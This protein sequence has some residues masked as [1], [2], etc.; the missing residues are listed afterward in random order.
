MKHQTLGKLL[1]CMISL[2][3]VCA[4]CLSAFAENA[5]DSE[6]FTIEKKTLVKYNGLGGEVTVPEGVEVLGAYAFERARVTKVN[7][8]ETLKEIKDHCFFGCEGLSEITLPASLRKLSDA[9]VF[10]GN[11]SL[12][13]IKV[14]EGNRQYKSV[15][16]V[17]FTANG[18]KML[19][20]PD[21]KSGA[22]EIPEG[23]RQLGYTVFGKPDMPSVTIPATLGKLDGGDFSL[24]PALK[25]IKISEKH[26]T[27]HMAGSAMYDRG[28][29]LIAYV[30]GDEKEELKPEDFEEKTA[31]IGSWAFQGNQYLKKV[32]FPE[33]VRKV[34][35]M[36]FSFAESLEEVIIPASVKSI[37]QYAFV[38]C[39]NL[40]KVTILNPW[41]TMPRDQRG[42]DPL[43]EN[44]FRRSNEDAVL[45]GPAGSNVQK[46]AEA[47]GLKFEA[48]EPAK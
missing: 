27:Y 9:Q 16:G 32:E 3:L 30:C 15:D 1:I 19:Y 38:Y 2:L 40:K 48:L 12:K 33:G 11:R 10:G 44:I 42:Q 43:K 46:Y 45:C 24:I 35:W 29:N 47:H 21:G 20:Y 17:V 39:P 36:C 41:V 5:T 28:R 18:Q 25:E 6:E 8:P 23:T 26:R 7:L 37:E 34:G 13:E 14:A 31:S 4:S 22:Y